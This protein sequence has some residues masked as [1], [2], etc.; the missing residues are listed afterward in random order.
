MLKEEFES[1]IGREVTWDE[2]KIIDTVYTW[3]PEDMTK[4]KIADIYKIGGMQMIK[5]LYPA[6]ARMLD[7]DARIRRLVNEKERFWKQ[8]KEADAELTRMLEV[9]RAFVAGEDRIDNEVTHK[10]IWRELNIPE[11]FQDDD[12]G[13][14]LF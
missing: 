1:R 7:I 10:A 13:E 9:K 11:D 8:I 12:H 4:D 6:A 3:Y 5:D 2:Y 14:D